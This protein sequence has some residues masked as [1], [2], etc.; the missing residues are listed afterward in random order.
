MID[1][2]V[3]VVMALAVLGFRAYTGRERH[4]HQGW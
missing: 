4:T 2:I 3:L 1:I